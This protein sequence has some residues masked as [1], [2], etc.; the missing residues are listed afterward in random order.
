[1]FSSGSIYAWWEN[2]VAPQL[3]STFENFHHS[4]I[5]KNLR[6]IILQDWDLNHNWTWTKIFT[7]I[8]ATLY[9]EFTCFWNFL[10]H[11]GTSRKGPV[12]LNGFEKIWCWSHLVTFLYNSMYKNLTAWTQNSCSHWIKSNLNGRSGEFLALG[13]KQ[14]SN[15]KPQNS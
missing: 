6:N 11:A 15:R 4:S 5:F 12:C 1:M 2:P 7:N 9:K 13:S 3:R 8:E 10:R 14:V